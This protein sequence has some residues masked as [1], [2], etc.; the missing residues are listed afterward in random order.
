M[1]KETREMVGWQTSWNA[2]ETPINWEVKGNP[3]RAHGKS[4]ARFELYYGASN[5]KEYLEKGGTK[6]D[7]KYD[8]QH[9]FLSLGNDTESPVSAAPDPLDVIETAMEE[10]KKERAVKRGKTIESEEDLLS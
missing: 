9:M 4:Y 2:D 1:P 3:K 10:H 6:G 5:V 8:W 7:L